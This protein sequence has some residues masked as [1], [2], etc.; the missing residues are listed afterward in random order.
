MSGVPNNAS[1]PLTLLVCALG[2][3]GG[4]VLAQWLFDV[5]RHCGH[6]AQ[7]TSVPG[8]AQR[9]GATTYYLEFAREP[10]QGTARAATQTGP[11]FGLMPLPGR[12][13]LLVS[14]ELLETTRQIGHGMTSAEQT[15]VI[16]STA[17]AFTTQ[18]RMVLGDGRVDEA[19][20]L[21]IVRQHALR[22]HVLD[23][24]TM[25]REAGTVVSAV[26]LGAVAASGVLPF[27]RA[28]YEAV[29]GGEGSTPSASARASLAGFARA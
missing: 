14:S 28:A 6:P 16:T 21:P 22:H 18:E 5:A 26:M 7:A 24:A 10:S 13:D 12:L 19:S 25:T 1:A 2:G 20:L 8:V 27:S 9:T 11:L 23:M 17:R 15:C 3:E 29:V 4:G